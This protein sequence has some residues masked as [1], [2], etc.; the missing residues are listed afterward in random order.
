MARNARHS[1]RCC[2][3]IRDTFATEPGLLYLRSNWKRQQHKLQAICV[4][5]RNNNQRTFFRSQSAS[6]RR[7]KTG[8]ARSAIIGNPPVRADNDQ[9]FRPG[10]VSV[11]DA[12]VGFVHHRRDGQSQHGGALLGTQGAFFQRIGL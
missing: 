4:A 12:V 11:I 10:G 1:Q 8:R 2:P 5:V 9:A 7:L 3:V 6:F